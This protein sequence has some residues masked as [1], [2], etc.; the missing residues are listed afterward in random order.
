MKKFNLFIVFIFLLTM[1]I[2]YSQTVTVIDKGTLKPLSDVE[3]SVNDKDV[4][5]TNTLGQA[6]IS[7]LKGSDIIKFHAIGYATEVYSFNTLSS[8]NFTVQLV[9]K[10]YST[11]EIVVSADRYEEK[12]KDV[13]RQ[14][15]VIDTKDI[16][17]ANVQTTAKLL[18]NTG[19]IF[20]IDFKLL[21]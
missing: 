13:P 18:E 20:G 4:I 6:D 10:S 5:T 14:I 19:K 3:I 21:R 9:E 2:A 12:L 15:E 17:Y 16:Q 11:D 8:I 1:N 7:N